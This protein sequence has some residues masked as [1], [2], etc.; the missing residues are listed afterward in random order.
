MVKVVVSLGAMLAVAT[1][2]TL[3]KYPQSVITNI[4]TTADPCQDLYQYACGTWMKNHS[5][6]EGQ[7][8]ALSLLDLEAQSVIEKILESNE[9]KI[10]A[11]FKACVDTDT[12]EKL[13]A[14]PLSK[15]LALIRKAKTKK[16]LLQVASHLAKHDVSGFA[17]IGVKG[18]DKDATLNKTT[19]IINFEKTLARFMLST[20]ESLLA[21]ASPQEYYPF[22]LYD[23]ATRFP[24]TI[25]PLLR[26]YGLNSTSP[27]PITPNNRVV[28]YDLNYFDKTEALLNK[29]SLEDLKTVIEYRLLL[30]SAPYLSSDFEMAHWTFFE[31]KLKGME[32]P[33]NRVS[34]CSA[35]AAKQLNDLMGTYYLKQTWSSDLSTKAMEIVNELTASVKTGIQSRLARRM[36]SHERADEIKE[37]QLFNTIDFDDDEY[38]EN[39]WKISRVVNEENI[40]QLGK[41]INKKVWQGISAQDANANYVPSLNRIVVPAA[42]LQ[43][44]FFDPQADPAQN[45]G[46]VGMAIGHELM[47]GYDNTG[48][49]YDA[50]GNLAPWW[51]NSSN[52]A[53]QS[54]AHC[55]VEQYGNFTTRSE[56]T[57][58]VIGNVDG[59][60][61][62]G[63]TIGDNGGLKA[64]FRAYQEYMKTHESKHTKEM[65]EKLFFLSFAQGWCSRNSDAALQALLQ[66]E[67]PP[68]RF[69]VFG[70]LQN[71]F[72]FSRVFNCP[73]DTFMNPAKK[74][75]L[76]IGMSSRM[77]TLRFMII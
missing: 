36:D 17:L 60:L 5:D 14:S 16:D 56:T 46:G 7:V 6:F 8:D 29:T 53:F 27:Q 49:N 30:A 61:T 9:P 40:G 24:F 37:P 2:G 1:A 70:A 57:G 77:Q 43:P 71:N 72:D 21:Q 48:R 31:Q 39:H 35:D 33:P 13:G 47:H 64:S 59:H 76:G 45:F 18:D 54:K 44:P 68:N 74:C 66:D 26:A 4:D 34:K 3:T 62:L 19:T 67:Y 23:A 63:E 11:Y 12:V 15:S 58:V 22:S 55:I 42:I 52:A 10:G 25:G 73:A 69:R 38:L 28:L 20:V 41:P 65:G 51:S 50:V 32:S 75:P